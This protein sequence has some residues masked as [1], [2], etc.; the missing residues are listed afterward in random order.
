[1][2]LQYFSQCFEP[3]ARQI[4]TPHNHVA[5]AGLHLSHFAKKEGAHYVRLNLS[6]EDYKGKYLHNFFSYY[7][8]FLE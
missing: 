1:M 8:I 6:Q 4:I 5:M 7:L 3:A 2:K